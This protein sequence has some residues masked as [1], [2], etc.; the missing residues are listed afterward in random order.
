MGQQGYRS[1]PL[2]RRAAGEG[3]NFPEHL[4]SVFGKRSAL[5]GSN[6]FNKEN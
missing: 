1:V 5:K 6:I 4:S 3:F 2:W